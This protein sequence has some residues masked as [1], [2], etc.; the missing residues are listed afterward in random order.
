MKTLAWLAA[1]CASMELAFGGSDVDLTHAP[2]AFE[3]QAGQAS[4]QFDF[5]ARGPRYSLGLSAGG[6][7]ICAAAARLDM[8]LV[9][10]D[11][12]ATAEGEERSVGKMSYFL[13]SDRSRWL[14]GVPTFSRVRYRTCWPG[15]D[16]VYHGCGG[17][18]EYDFELEPGTDP[19]SI[20]IAFDG[21]REA[22]V[23]VDGSLELSTATGTMR[24]PPPLVSQGG[25]EIEGSWRLEEDGTATFELQGYDPARAAVI[26]PVI[27][28]TALVG[29]AGEDV[30]RAVTRDSA[31]NIVIAGYTD[32]AAFPSLG[33]S[34]GNKGAGTDAF[35]MVLDPSGYEHLYT[36]FFGGLG[37]DRAHAVAL[38]PHNDQLVYLAG[39]T[40]SADFPVVALPGHVPFQANRLGASDAFLL[41]LDLDLDQ[42]AFSTYLGGTS[43]DDGLG[44][45]V[46][47][48]SQ[49]C[50]VGQTFSSDF[51]VL[52]AL[53]FDFGGSVDGFATKIDTNGDS[54]VWSTYMGGAGEDRFNAIAID[55]AD[56]HYLVGGTW[57]GDP[58]FEDAIVQH[59]N[60]D[61][62]WGVQKLLSGSSS[63][64][65]TAV[66]L[67]E[68]GVVYV[69]GWTKSDDFP[70][71]HATQSTRGGNEDGFLTVLQPIALGDLFS[72]F[73]GG[74]G[75][76]EIRGIDAVSDQAFVVGST[77][78]DDLP[79]VDA[80]SNRL[81]G[82]Q[83]GFVARIYTALGFEDVSYA[84]YFPGGDSEELYGVACDGADVVVVG[85]VRSEWSYPDVLATVTH[86]TLGTSFDTSALV[87][88]IDPDSLPG[89]G[90]AEFA[91]ST[92]QATDGEVFEFFVHRH[93]GNLY[94]GA[95][96]YLFVQN[97]ATVPGLG[98]QLYF[99]Y[100]EQFTSGGI[101]LGPGG[102]PS[103][104]FELRLV[105]APDGASIG[106]RNVLHVGVGEPTGGGGGGGGGGSGG[107]SGCPFS[108][109]AAHTSLE[110]GL[111]DLRGFRDEW[112]VP[113]ALGRELVRA[114]YASGPGVVRWLR[115]HPEWMPIARATTALAIGFARHPPDVRARGTDLRGVAE[116]P[117][118]PRGKTDVV[119]RLR[120]R[121]HRRPPM[122]AR[123][124]DTVLFDLDGTL[125]DSIELIRQSYEHTLRRHGREPEHD[126]WLSGLGRPLKW[127]F[128]QFTEDEREIEAMIATYRSFNL[129]HH[130]RM[131]QPFSGV[132]EALE[133]LVARGVKLGI[134]TSKLRSGADRGL[135]H[136]GFEA[137]WFGAIVGADDVSAH[138]PD[139]APVLR[140]LEMLASVPRRA[141]MV[142]DSPHDLASGRSAG[143][144]TAA[145]AWGPFSRELL[146]AT[147]PDHWLETP[148]Q[149][150]ELVP[151][152]KTT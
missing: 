40:Y 11:E 132:R 114:Y 7:S 47:Y 26:D 32:S 25:C 84:T 143:T 96:N 94:P 67:D 50:V 12:G 23:A 102:V 126:F 130:D 91:I 112:L 61:G 120:V 49:P 54:L 73:F 80:V 142:G 99:Q 78:S 77:D 30:A 36:A 92:D 81:G 9:G 129:A 38:D 101:D 68:Y 117:S 56:N 134:V 131:V 140:A 100:G 22:R 13:G 148:A 108:S 19:R 144:A 89:I 44:L 116:R 60:P 42:L 59:V 65:V 31:G 75:T 28:W 76:D 146:L 17:A 98:G 107:D 87:A 136:C 85:Q 127:Q 152:G 109:A 10:A 51:P 72:T 125:I 135:S 62:T 145:V 122:G 115:A 82:P 133:T 63:E 4:A 128:A 46:D 3:P 111:D 118:A 119:A 110:P 104:D 21:V 53:Q 90:V 2:L 113:N 5:V 124:I 123:I 27:E 93:D 16:V 88:W 83:D 86:G 6:A 8:R 15:V 43:E 137:G 55:G 48:F 58:G 14:S 57:V 39:T 20:R 141:V 70:L 1:C 41:K 97:G 121:D 105:Q 18:L 71:L 37:A 138:K 69:G 64:E 35:V 74:S 150:A 52:A 79:T 149:I 33:G 103:G 106:S 45:A 95:V 147:R 29:G 139:P 66:A 24:Q 151:Q 34:F